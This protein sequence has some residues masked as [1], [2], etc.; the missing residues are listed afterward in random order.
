M[1][2]A[3]NHASKPEGVELERRGS[4]A[5]ITL[6]RPELGNAIDLSL[7]RALTDAVGECDADDR[8]RCVAITGAGSMFC[9]GGDLR[10][11]AVAGDQMPALLRELAGR[12]HEALT[13]LSQLRKPILTVINGPAAGAGLSLSICS[14]I[15]LAA[16][17]AHFSA[18]YGGVGLTPDG[19][20][21]WWLS[22]LVGLR[23]AQQIILA[24][25]RVSAAEAESM[26]LI[27][28]SVD[29]DG[30]MAEAA[31]WTERLSRSATQALA[32]S[33]RLLLDGYTRSLREQLDAEVDAIVHAGAQEECREGVS[34][35][36]ERRAPMFDRS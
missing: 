3:E 15:A 11:F 21:S 17:S 19:G 5:W 13:I 8:I 9:V 6:N 27:T 20:M 30:L 2:F 31:R 26:G 4:T 22:R 23:R 24:N 35:F 18:A 32:V 34:A 7:A 16:R 14:D 10:A 25:R 36:L 1:R 33:R 28:Q 12:L 29:D